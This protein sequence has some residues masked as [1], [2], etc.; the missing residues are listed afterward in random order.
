MDTLLKMQPKQSFIIVQWQKPEL[1]T[2][3][4]NT[5]GSFNTRDMSA[6]V[7]GALTRDNVDMIIAFSFPYSCIN[8][9]LAEAYAA[10]FGMTWCIQN[11]HTSFT[12]EMDSC[13]VVEMLQG[14]K[15]T[16]YMMAN[17]TEKIARMRSK[18]NI[19]V[20]HYCREAN[21]LAEYLAKL[22]NKAHNGVFFFSSQ[23]LP[24]AVKGPFL[25]DK[26]KFRV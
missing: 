26:I 16:N 2:L 11:G 7:G 25:W 9:N 12:L 15:E 14:E 13:L 6:G 22:A 23:Q 24:K 5:N 18:A 17:V 19:H 10:L 8:H 4:L 1:G 3:K 21:Q 20:N